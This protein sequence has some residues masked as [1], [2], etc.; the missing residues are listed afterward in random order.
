MWLHPPRKIELSISDE[1]FVLCE[2][3]EKET[4]QDDKKKAEDQ[5]FSGGKQSKNFIEIKREKNEGKKIYNENIK[6]LGK[7]NS[8]LKDLLYSSTELM[9]NVEKSGKMLHEDLAFKIRSGLE[10]F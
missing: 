1:L 6:D 7:L 4:M 3:S 10:T 8:M 9:L 5:G 2:K